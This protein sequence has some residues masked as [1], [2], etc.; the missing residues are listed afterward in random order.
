MQLSYFFIKNVK[1]TDFKVVSLDLTW[2]GGHENILGKN[3]VPRN[4]L[5]IFEYHCFRK[6]PSHV[7]GVLGDADDERIALYVTGIVI[8]V[9]FLCLILSLP[10]PAVSKA[11]TRLQQ[12]EQGTHLSP[13]K[14][15]KV[16]AS[17]SSS[18]SGS[19]TLSSNASSSAHSDEKWYE[20]GSSRTGVRPDSE[21]NGY[22]QGASTDSGIDAT[23]YGATGSGG[24]RAKDRLAQE[25]SPLAPDSPG[26]PG[27]SAYPAQSPLVFPPAPDSGSYT[28]SDAASHSSTLSSGQSGSPMGPGCSPSSS[29]EESALATSPTSQAS[30]SPGG[31]KSFYPRQGATSKYLIGWRKPGGT[32]NSVDFGKTRKRHQSDGLLGGQPQLRAQ[33]RAQSPQRVTTSSLQE[34]LKKL[35]TLDSPP[36]SSHDQKPSFP[37]PPPS[38]RSL[39]R[40][41]SDE[42]IYSGQRE[43][44]FSGHRQ[45]PN[46]LLFS[47]STIPRSPTARHAPPRQPSHK[48]LG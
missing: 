34:D 20:I 32:I 24:S 30:L 21:L 31:P 6:C 46:D 39:Q 13:N 9:S 18:Q 42:S 41:L 28:L 7:S 36:P 5:K 37:V 33:L 43:P 26:P 11:V 47:C 19:N 17:Y 38:R 12:Q 44:A 48:S 40:T 23:S 25:T 2:G 4:L 14:N 10:D 45:T 16:E 29:Q 22:L 8:C 3:G 1:C 15:I 27:S 35:I